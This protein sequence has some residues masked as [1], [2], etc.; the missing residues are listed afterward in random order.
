[1]STT[2]LQATETAGHAQTLINAIEERAAEVGNIIR[3]IQSH[4][5]ARRDFK[6]AAVRAL[7]GSDNPETGKPHSA[8]SAEKAVEADAE[9]RG[10][11]ERAAS[12]EAR[13]Q[14]A[15][16]RYEAAKLR[17]RL[18]VEL[19]AAVAGGLA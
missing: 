8:S 2:I 18:A 13:K 17:A 6:V 7:I 19:A 11:A 5:D 12:L 10:F 1:M 15:F 3:E 9:Y 16:G 14:E 4:D